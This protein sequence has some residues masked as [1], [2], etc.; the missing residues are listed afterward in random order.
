MPPT[1]D[2]ISSQVIK[3]DF[4]SDYLKIEINPSHF[5]AE[6]ISWYV[7]QVMRTW[8]PLGDIRRRGLADVVESAEIEFSWNGKHKMNDM[9]QFRKD[10]TN[11]VLDHKQPKRNRQHFH[12]F[13]HQ[14]F[15]QLG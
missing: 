1:S 8:D 15:V 12:H 7:F 5:Y 3:S 4:L 13:S 11:F 2:K 6:S 14:M 10:V 9:I